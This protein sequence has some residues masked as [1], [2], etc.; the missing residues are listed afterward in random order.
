MFILEFPQNLI[1]FMIFIIYGKLLKRP[2]YKYH[3]AYVTHIEGRW[4]AVSLSRFIFAD[5][6]CYRSDIIKHEYGHRQQSKILL[7]LYLPL[8]GLPSFLWNKLFK[9]YRS[10]RAR[11]YYWFYTEE[12]ANRLGGYRAKK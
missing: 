7:F 3:D 11:S 9:A 8:I 1:G 10:K 5:D 4:G 6:S 12:W 2:Y